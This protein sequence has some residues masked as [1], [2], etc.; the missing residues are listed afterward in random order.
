VR[1]LDVSSYIDV[2]VEEG[3]EIGRLCRAGSAAAVRHCP[4]WTG[5]DLLAHLVAYQRFVTDLVAG[6]T[7]V[8][9]E[10]PDVGGAEALSVW[11]AEHAAFAELLRGLDPA[12]PVPNWSILPDVADFW[13][14]RSS[15]EFAV[16]RWDAGTTVA[17]EPAPI[18]G[19]VARD[20]I[21]EYFDTLVDTAVA[22]GMPQAQHPATLRYDLTDLDLVLERHI[23]APGPVTT[24]RGTASDLL[25]GL[26]HRRDATAYVVDGD[27]ALIAAWPHV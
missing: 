26:W 8:G 14:R 6:T 3:A 15:Q 22:A 21:E 19:N 5:A 12:T 18:R 20:G 24:L 23:R 17:D 16:H 13:Q 11:D 2:V 25:L 10:L 1:T 7:T 9:V 4:D 27:R